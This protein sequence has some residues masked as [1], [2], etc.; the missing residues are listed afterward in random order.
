VKVSCRGTAGEA[1]RVALKLTLAQGLHRG[2]PVNLGSVTVT[3][4]A[5]SAKK[6]A[7]AL[8]GTGRRLLSQDGSLRATLTATQGSHRVSSQTLTFRRAHKH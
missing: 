8:N 6:V 4:R 1:C 5:G 2:L 3:V 7:I